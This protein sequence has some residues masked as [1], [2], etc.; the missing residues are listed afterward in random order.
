MLRRLGDIDFSN[1]KGLP[2]E[3]FTPFFYSSGAVLPLSFG[4]F[5][6]FSK[7]SIFVNEITKFWVNMQIKR[8]G[9]R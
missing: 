7:S 6:N 1:L 2:L 3:N 5:V 4:F 8:G 9:G